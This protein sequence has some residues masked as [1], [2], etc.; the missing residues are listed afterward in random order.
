M[1]CT[2][3]PEAVRK[4]GNQ[5]LYSTGGVNKSV[6]ERSSFWDQCKSGNGRLLAS[7]VPIGDANLDLRFEVSLLGGPALALRSDC[8]PQIL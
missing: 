8:N 6:T 7:A 5:V 1:S 4:L 3:L 2:A